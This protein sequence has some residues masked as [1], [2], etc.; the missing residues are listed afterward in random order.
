MSQEVKIAVEA[1][2]KAGKILSER[3]DDIGKISFKEFHDPVTEVDHLAEQAI[4]STIKKLFP[5]T[6]SSPKNLEILKEVIRQVNGSSTHSMG[7]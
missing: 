6:I 2:L 4:I 5:T 3:A 7:H 1:A